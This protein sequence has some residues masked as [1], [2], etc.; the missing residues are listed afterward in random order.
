MATRAEKRD[1]LIMSGKKPFGLPF[2]ILLNSGEWVK[3]VRYE[4]VA[5]LNGDQDFPD[6]AFAIMRDRNNRKVL[7]R[8][9]A[10]RMM[11]G[12]DGGGGF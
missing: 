9:D 10:V 4:K 6:R 8:L 12:V 5:H 3:G 7:V 2:N 1:D 11:Q